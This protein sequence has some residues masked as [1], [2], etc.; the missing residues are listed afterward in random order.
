MPSK[1]SISYRLPQVTHLSSRGIRH[2]QIMLIFILL[3]KI[4]FLSPKHCIPARSIATFIKCE[5]E[6]S[7][8]MDILTVQPAEHSSALKSSARNKDEY[9]FST[10]IPSVQLY[11]IFFPG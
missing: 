6:I 5:L 10:G 11:G 9:C 4:P 3:N 8:E 7:V 2:C 1:M